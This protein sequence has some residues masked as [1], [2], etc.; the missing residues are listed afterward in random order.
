[1]KAN[2]ESAKAEE[3]IAINLQDDIEGRLHVVEYDAAQ[4]VEA[5]DE[6]RQDNGRRRSKRRTRLRRRPSGRRRRARS[7]RSRRPKTSTCSRGS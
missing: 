2:I 4:A 5:A 3:R 6:A 7:S 1:M